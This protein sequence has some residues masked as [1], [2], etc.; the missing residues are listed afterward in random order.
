[1]DFFFDGGRTY[2]K[3]VYDGKPPII[4]PSVA[5]ETHQAGF[6]LWGNGTGLEIECLGQKW[7]FGEEALLQSVMATQRREPEWVLSD[8]Y[9]AMLLAAISEA[10]NASRLSVNVVTGL[11]YD[12]Y[13]NK[14]LREAYRS[15]LLGEHVIQRKGRN[16]QRI[17]IEQVLILTQNF[18]PALFHLLDEKGNPQISSHKRYI[19]IIG[20][21]S[22]TTELGTIELLAGEFKPKAVETQSRSEPFGILS[23][24]HLLRE[25][26]RAEFS[27]NFKDFE[28]VQ[29]LQTGSTVLWG[30]EQNVR[31]I[32]AEVLAPFFSKV[33]G[34]AQDNWSERNPIPLS[35]LSMLIL[36]GGGAF[37]AD[38]V[39]KLHPQVLRSNEPHLDTVRGYERAKKMIDRGKK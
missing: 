33:T 25:K 18:A 14:G 23:A 30:K 39:F 2:N 29:A 5:G 11:P 7:L 35:R 21:G 1:M 17:S 24:I 31:P 26:F 6:D 36:T 32:V 3:A 8:Q 4:F 10:S 38:E 22:Y 15:S 34:I 28:V 20:I 19:G 12:D 27:V 13:R 9:L 37:Q 16:S